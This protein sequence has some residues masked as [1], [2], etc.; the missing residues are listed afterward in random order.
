M[1]IADSDDFNTAISRGME[2]V[3]LGAPVIVNND[4]DL[5]AYGRV[6]RME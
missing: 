3:V 6:R 2:A 4:R 1:I 5:S